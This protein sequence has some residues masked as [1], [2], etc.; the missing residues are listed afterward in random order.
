M[1]DFALGITGLTDSLSKED[2]EK[3]LF[4]LLSTG[5]ALQWEKFFAASK[6]GS[7]FARIIQTAKKI[8]LNPDRAPMHR[9]ISPGRLESWSKGKSL[10]EPKIMA[11]I[12]SEW[13]VHRLRMRQ[14][15]E[16]RTQE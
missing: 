5:T 10:P 9:N 11:A 12:C 13:I 14:V 3:K 6:N 8:E 1:T 15:L 16:S 2:A 4:E 7:A